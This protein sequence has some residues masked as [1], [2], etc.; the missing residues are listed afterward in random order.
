MYNFGTC[1]R[2]TVAQW[3]LPEKKTCFDAGNFENRI[4]TS[5]LACTKVQT[6]KV[7]KC[8]IFP[9]L[10]EFSGET[11]SRWLISARHLLGPMIRLGFRNPKKKKRVRTNENLETSGVGYFT[12]GG[13]YCIQQTHSGK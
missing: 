9:G 11:S 2:R 6:S 12:G 13:R 8:L 5:V 1:V 4:T 7:R 3:R 10:A